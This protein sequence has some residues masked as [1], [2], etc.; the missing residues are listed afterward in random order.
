LVVRCVVFGD[1]LRDDTPNAF[2]KDRGLGY[3][4]QTDGAEH[5]VFRGA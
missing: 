2:S 3:L 1:Y 5:H 4:A